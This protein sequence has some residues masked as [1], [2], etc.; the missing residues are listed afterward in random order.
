MQFVHAEQI[1]ASTLKKER[2]WAVA[3]AT[4]LVSRS[5]VQTL[6]RAGLKVVVFTPNED[7]TWAKARA[8]GADKVLTDKPH[9]YSE[10]V[11]AND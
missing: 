9:E 2:L 6:K 7:A 4:N 8:A 1:P 11:A 10:W 3:V 5:Y